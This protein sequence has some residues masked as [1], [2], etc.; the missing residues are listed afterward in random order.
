MFVRKVI[1]ISAIPLLLTTI[2]YL[3]EN[4]AFSVQLFSASDAETSKLDPQI[5]QMDRQTLLSPRLSLIQYIKQESVDIYHSYSYFMVTMLFLHFLVIPLLIHGVRSL[6][7]LYKHL[8]SSSI[9][10]NLNLV[11][12]VKD[13]GLSLNSSIEKSIAY[14]CNMSKIIFQY[15]LCYCLW[16]LVF[17]CLFS[18]LP[19]C[20]FI[21]SKST[22]VVLAHYPEHIDEE[23][24]FAQRQSQHFLTQGIDK[25]ESLSHHSLKEVKDANERILD[26]QNYGIDVVNVLASLIAFYPLNYLDSTF[27]LLKPDKKTVYIYNSNGDLGLIDVSNNNSPSISAFAYLGLVSG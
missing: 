26:V 2:I 5:S 27:L 1:P 7:L 24:G 16:M 13:R 6:K 18:I 12:K 15:T 23:G 11:T 10:P 21:S 4:T 25:H 9:D 3:V 14:I 8:Y 19:S 22:E 17:S 20:S